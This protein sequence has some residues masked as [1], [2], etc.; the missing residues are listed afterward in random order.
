MTETSSINGAG[1]AIA[2]ARA[3]GRLGAGSESRAIA[4]AD[5]NAR[6][7]AADSVSLSPEARAAARAGENEPVRTELVN[8]VR[9]EL[10]ART[11]MTSEKLDAAVDRLIDEIRNG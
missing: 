11:Y 2:R 7:R 5:E 3:T 6:L 9:Q 4:A 1:D 10:D 8:R